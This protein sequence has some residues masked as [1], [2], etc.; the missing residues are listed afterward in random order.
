MNAA[1][2]NRCDERG[3]ISLG[4][5]AARSCEC[6]YAIA[7]QANALKHLTLSE[8]VAYALARNEQERE[9]LASFD[10]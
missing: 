9:Q 2:C 3:Y 1:K 7:R 10:N 6:D 8:L 4:P 5:Y